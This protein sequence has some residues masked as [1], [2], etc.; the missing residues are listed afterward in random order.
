MITIIVLSAVA[1]LLT[2]GLIVWF[3]VDLKRAKSGKKA[4]LWE[5]KDK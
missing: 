3:A 5:R 1:V 2:A 4:V